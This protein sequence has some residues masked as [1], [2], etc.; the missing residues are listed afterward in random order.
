[1]VKTRSEMTRSTLNAWF[2]YV[3]SKLS[4]GPGINLSL[5][6]SLSPSLSH[7]CVY[8]CTVKNLS[9]MQDLQETHSI[10][11][12]ERSPRAGHGN[13]LQYSCLENPHGP[14]SLAGYSPFAQSQTLVNWLYIY[15][16]TYPLA[17]LLLL[18]IFPMLLLFYESNPEKNSGPGDPDV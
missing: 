8:V 12:W 13:P 11:G 17:H 7:V 14:R 9:S 4:P 2:I 18:D 5:S 1:M 6:L 3:M 10:P 15:P 16:L